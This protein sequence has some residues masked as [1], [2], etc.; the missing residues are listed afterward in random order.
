MINPPQIQRCTC[1]GSGVHFQ[2]RDVF[3]GQVGANYIYCGIEDLTEYVRGFGFFGKDH[4]IYQ[5]TPSRPLTAAESK[6]VNEAFALVPQITDEE[7]E[8]IIAE[9]HGLDERSE[10]MAMPPRD[11]DQVSRRQGVRK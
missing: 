11:F 10:P 3:Y 7:S 2:V 9:V 1:G 4:W 5:C 8:R 6:R